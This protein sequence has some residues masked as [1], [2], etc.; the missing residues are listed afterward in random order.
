MPGFRAVGS[1]DIYMLLVIFYLKLLTN[2]SN[3]NRLS[4]YVL[5]DAKEQIQINHNFFTSVLVRK[6]SA[7][8]VVYQEHSNASLKQIE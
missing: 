8:F 5:P 6:K 2:G 7:F 1:T 3:L 4:K